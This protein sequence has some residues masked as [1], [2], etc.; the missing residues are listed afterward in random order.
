[1]WMCFKAGIVT[2]CELT[3]LATG[4]ANESERWGVE[5]R[6]RL[7]GELADQEDGRLAPQNNHLVGVWMPASFVELEENQRGTKVKR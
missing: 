4:Q 6:K 2:K 1:M 5:A 7:T 3:L